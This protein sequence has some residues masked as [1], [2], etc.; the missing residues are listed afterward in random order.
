MKVG[1]TGSLASGKST[2]SK[3]LSANRG[4]LFSADNVVKKL[5]TNKSLRKLIS[6]RF[7]ISDNSNLKNTLK[8][9]FLTSRSNIKKLEKI[10]HPLVRKEMRKFSIKNRNKKFVFFEIPLL[11]ESKLMKNFNI[12][13]FIKAKK[14]IRLKR[15]I[16]KGGN[17]KFF[18]TL[19][20][21]QLSDTKKIKYCDH[22]IVNEKNLT[23]LKRKLLDI[24]KQYE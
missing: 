20:K 18:M 1:I 24:L 14:N 23:I 9:N 7:K 11:I 16:K 8:K 17:K 3:I 15:F 6:K 12:I 10:I 19:N 21:K 13:F 4:P 5:Y 2:A 22:V